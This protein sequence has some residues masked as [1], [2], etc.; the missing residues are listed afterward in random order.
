L[1]GSDGKPLLNLGELTTQQKQMA[2][3]LFGQNTVSN[4]M[5]GTE[6]IGRAQ[7]IGTNG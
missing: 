2:G 3:E 1:I 6:R 4:L 5:P 7:G